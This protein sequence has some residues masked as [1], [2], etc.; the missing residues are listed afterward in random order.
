MSV[1]WTITS[2]AVLLSNS[3]TFSINSFSLV[4]IAPD[5]SPSSTMAM[6][7]SSDT[8]SFRWIRFKMGRQSSWIA[9]IHRL[10]PNRIS[11]IWP[12]GTK[13]T[14]FKG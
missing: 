5:S 7:L 14:S 9:L 6:I 8:S 12:S 13:M 2:L 1:R 10:I 3:R 4:W 11:H